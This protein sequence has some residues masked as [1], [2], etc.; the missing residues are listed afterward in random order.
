MVPYFPTL[1]VALL[2][3]RPLV[4][5]SPSSDLPELAVKPDI[6]QYHLGPG[7]RLEIKVLGAD[8]LNRTLT[9]F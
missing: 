9:R 5:C 2:A 4:G 1:W 3:L 7:D 8:E 6:T